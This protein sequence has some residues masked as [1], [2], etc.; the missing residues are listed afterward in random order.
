MTQS[1]H[2]P[3]P[4]GY[5]MR[6]WAEEDVEAVSQLDALVFGPDSWSHE[7]FRHEYRA[8]TE[9]NPHSFYQVITYGGVVIGFAGLLY[10]PPFADVTTIGVH[11]DHTA[12]K[13]G[14][15]LLIWLMDTAQE[16]GAMDIL[17]EVRAD[18]T[19]AQR[20]YTDNGFEHIHTRPK[21][22]PGGIDAWVMRKRLRQRGPSSAV[23]LTDKE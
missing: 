4:A 11:P 10:G 9:Q 22:Y 18:N 17:L 15:A 12:Q 8:S 5:V 7:I 23:A 20:L 1:T 6:T 19:R 3:L 14:A 16:L 13:L 21:Y 2:V